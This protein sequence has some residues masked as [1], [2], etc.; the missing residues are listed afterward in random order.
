M[1][2]KLPDRSQRQPLRVQPGAPEL[3]VAALPPVPAARMTH[4]WG[5]TRADGRVAAI[6]LGRRWRQRVAVEIGPDPFVGLLLAS[7]D[8]LVADTGSRW[9]LVDVGAGRVIGSGLRRDGALALDAAGRTLY[10]PAEAGTVE[11]VDLATGAVRYVL[12]PRFGDAYRRE[13]VDARGSGVVIGSVRL[14][15]P[16]GAAPA[17]LDAVLERLEIGEPPALGAQ[18]IVKARRT[19]LFEMLPPP[20]LAGS[21]ER[22]VCVRPGAIDWFD[23]ELTLTASFAGEFTPDTVCLPDDRHLLMSVE[24]PGETAEVWSVDLTGNVRRLCNLKGLRLLQA[25]VVVSDARLYAIAERMVV[26]VDCGGGIAWEMPHEGIR[27]G[28]AAGGDAL[29][30]V[31]GTRVEVVQRDHKVETLFA[32]EKPIRSNAVPLASGEIAVA[33]DGYVHLFTTAPAAAP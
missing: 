21:A 19:A 6:D 29:L 32:C 7:G 22:V 1:D 25:P 33:T 24:L 14:P 3:H 26:A 10:A 17:D 12:K 20:L 30:I 15:S 2:S 4:R 9:S 11:A 23:G 5:S 16:H 31:A 13:Y 27:H 18:G 28:L 8:R